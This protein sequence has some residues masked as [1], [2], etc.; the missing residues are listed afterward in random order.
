MQNPPHVILI[1]D[2]YGATQSVI[3]PATEAIQIIGRFRGGVNTVTHIASIRPD[4]ECMS[5]NEIDSWIEGAASIF[6]GWK[7]NWHEPQI[8]VNVLCCRKPSERIHISPIWMRMENPT[9]F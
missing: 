4:L 6:N 8:S 2:L 9:R 7:N 3:D 5:A 1:N